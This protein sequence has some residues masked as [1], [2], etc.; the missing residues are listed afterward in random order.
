VT[1]SFAQGIAKEGSDIDILT[2]VDPNDQTPNAVVEFARRQIEL[3]IDFGLT[4]DYTY[5]TDVISMD[6]LN[7]CVAGRCIVDCKG[8]LVCGDLEDNVEFD[9]RVWLYQLLCHDFQLL[10][11]SMDKLEKA[12]SK[13][14][15]IALVIC[16]GRIG[17]KKILLDDLR[18]DILKP[19]TK[20]GYY[21]NDAQTERLLSEIST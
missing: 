19:V 21:L 9:Y 4:P 7:D 16:A 2:V 8:N 15:N 1:G 6:Q 3:Q 11:G 14:L 17:F 18:F 10:A 20:N 5:P 13:A 12:T